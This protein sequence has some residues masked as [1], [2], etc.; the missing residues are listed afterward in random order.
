MKTFLKIWLS[1]SFIAIGIGIGL[2]FIA[3]GTGAR[4]E[5]ASAF[6]DMNE[7]Y[8]G[9][10]RLNFDISYGEVKI[11]KGNEFS[12][13]AKNILEDELDSY[14]T[15]G[16]W[17]IKEDDSKFINVFG[18]RLPSRHIISWGDHFLPR[19]TITI[20]EDFEA[21][22]YILSIAAGSV[23]A[24]KINAAEGEFTVEAGSL[25]I[26]QLTVTDKSKYKVGTGEMQ[27]LDIDVK[28]ITVDCGV[29]KVDIDGTIIGDNNITCGIGDVDIDLNGDEVDYS[30]QI[31]CGIGDVDIDGDS[32]NSISNKIINNKNANNNLYLDCGVGS[33][34]V[35][36][37]E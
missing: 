7:S 21:E 11:V 18:L 35:D 28:D 12:I 30:Y 20:P 10:E 29:G 13:S 23:E 14:V 25:V 15:D 2:L 9:I 37:N 22:N 17:Y 36:F 5:D 26:D 4:W 1:I 3:A 24:E 16:T 32:Y 19:I 6:S 33:I 34:S 31:S 8:E 27:L